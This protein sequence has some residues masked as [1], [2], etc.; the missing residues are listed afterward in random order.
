MLKAHQKKKNWLNE[1]FKKS[2]EI[3]IFVS[4]KTPNNSVTSL[5]MVVLI[6]LV[7]VL[8]VNLDNEYN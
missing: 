1:K 2:H 5:S 4:K 3:L 8:V 7:I 6:V